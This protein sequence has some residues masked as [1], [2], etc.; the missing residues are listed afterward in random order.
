MTGN[1]HALSIPYQIQQAKK[2][3]RLEAKNSRLR[4]ALAQVERVNRQLDWNNISVDS[5]IEQIDDA[6]ARAKG[7]QP[8]EGL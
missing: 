7:P 1:Y 6:I 3:K 4:A 8:V 2:V 5:A